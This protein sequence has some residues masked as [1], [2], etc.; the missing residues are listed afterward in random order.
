MNSNQYE[1]MM[2]SIIKYAPIESGIQT[3]IYMFLYEIF[4]NVDFDILI[5]DRMQKKSQYNTYSGIPDIAIINNNSDEIVFCVETKAI[6]ENLYD[7]EEQF[8]GHLL[9][10]GKT[11][12]TNGKQ[13]IC[14]DIDYYIENNKSNEIE[15]CWINKEVESIQSNVFKTIEKDRILA[16]LKSSLAHTPKNEENREV[17]TGLEKLINQKQEEIKNK[18]EQIDR[19]INEN[20]IIKGAID[21]PRFNITISERNK[22]S[23]QIISDKFISLIC[24]LYEFVKEI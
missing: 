11:I 4:D 23:E 20:Q 24:E 2:N 5:I 12:A 6:S 7:Y 8:L 22:E 3:L 14:Y 18:S 9:T 17:R 10:Y 1:K 21:N 13:W 16:E 19:F 15:E